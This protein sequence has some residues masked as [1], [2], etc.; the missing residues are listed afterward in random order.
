[1]TDTETQVN[2]IIQAMVET[3][4][5]VYDND[6]KGNLV[7]KRGKNWGKK[8]KRPDVIAGKR[9]RWIKDD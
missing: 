6:E 5:L 7:L 4:E 9:I 3:G 1:M 8:M 2:Y